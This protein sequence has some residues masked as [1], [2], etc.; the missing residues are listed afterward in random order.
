M[1]LVY[2]LARYVNVAKVYIYGESVFRVGNIL[3]RKSG[4]YLPNIVKF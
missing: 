3:K 4:K 2:C 1:A